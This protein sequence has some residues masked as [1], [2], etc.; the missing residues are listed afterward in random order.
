MMNC[1]IWNV[2]AYPVP[3]KLCDILDPHWTEIDIREKLGGTCILIADLQVG[4][5]IDI[6]EWYLSALLQQR[7]PSL[8]HDRTSKPKIEVS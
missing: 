4:R 2:N 6:I 8:E 5:M 7:S 1:S 3:Y